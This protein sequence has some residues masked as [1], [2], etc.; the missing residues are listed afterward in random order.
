MADE[1]TGSLYSLTNQLIE[2][3]QWLHGH[4]GIV[5][6]VSWVIDAFGHGPTMPY[7]FKISGMDNTVIQRLHYSW[8]KYL[9]QNKFSDF[10]WVQRWD[11]GKQFA[12][13]VHNNPFD[14]YDSRT[15]CG[16]DTEICV[17]YYFRTIRGEYT[18]YCLN[19]KPITDEN[20]AS[21]A[22]ELVGQFQ[23]SA[24]ISGSNVVLVPL[25]DDFVFDRE[26]EWDQQYGNYTLLMNY[27]NAN[28][29]IFNMEIS[30]GTVSSYFNAIQDKNPKLP[31]FSGDFFPYSDVFTSGEPAHW[32]GFYGT[33]PYWKKLYKEAENYLRSA[34]ILYAYG[35]NFQKNGQNHL[36]DAH[37]K[38]LVSA[39]R[40]FGLFAHHDG[41]TGTS[42]A[43]VMEDFGHKLLHSHIVS[44]KIQEDCLSHILSQGTTTSSLVVERD[45]QYSSFGVLPTKLT[46]R[47]DSNVFLSQ[48]V[49]LFN[50]IAFRRIQL[51][52]MQVTSRLVRVVDNYGRAIVS[53]I[54]PVAEYNSRLNGIS[55]HPSIYELN[56]LAKLEPL[57][58]HIYE[59]KPSF[60]GDPFLSNLATV[61]CRGCILDLNGRFKMHPAFEFRSGYFSSDENI[62]LENSEQ[63]LELDWVT[64]YLKRV[65]DKVT[66]SSKLVTIS[67]GGYAS[68]S[69]SSGAYLMKLDRTRTIEIGSSPTNPAS[70]LSISGPVTSYLT[71]CSKL[72]S[73]TTRLLAHPGYGIHL[74]NVVDLGTIPAEVFMRIN[75]EIDSVS[76]RTGRPEMFTDQNG[77]TFE[78]RDYIPENGYEGNVFPV[79]S[80]AY[81]HDLRKRKDFQFLLTG[82]MG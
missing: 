56:F 16:P 52:T 58:V 44:Q 42:T 27:I 13:N 50:S 76:E 66:G 14:M 64:G 54:N 80:M 33:R 9:A 18:D 78:R 40:S 75:T 35:R 65:I 51:V 67:F 43:R 19:S 31:T 6:N 1:A 71:S 20:I 45:E 59:I 23:R 15:S 46:R 57:T 12:I 24:S 61:Q 81:I 22:T 37:Y 41:T 2:G 39:R 55:L 82:H 53:Q 72:L 7:L 62:I 79:T 70:L 30:F 69:Q 60:W 8:K 5:P 47:I 36:M 3:R 25:G 26:E 38:S 11:S 28:P 68:I 34:E 48:K 73:V 21:S 10:T 32:T 49:L 77:Y 29:A 74:E 63:V 4:V 17:K